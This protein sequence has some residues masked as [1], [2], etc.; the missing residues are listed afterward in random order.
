MTLYICVGF[1]YGAIS[2]V[3]TFPR[4][5]TSLDVIVSVGDEGVAEPLEDFMVILTDPS[6][7]LTVAGP[8]ATVNI[9]PQG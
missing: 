1:D 8:P 5:V 4:G 9:L 2:M 3:L 6:A 7:D